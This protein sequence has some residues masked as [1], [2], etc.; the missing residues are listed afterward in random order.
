MR[1]YKVKVV[2]LLWPCLGKGRHNVLWCTLTCNLEV[3]SSMPCSN[4]IASV[5]LCW[6]S[7]R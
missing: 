7:F 6:S 1:D 5:V 2:A 3:S 4:E